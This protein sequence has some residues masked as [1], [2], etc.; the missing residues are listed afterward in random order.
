MCKVNPQYKK[1]VRNER[2]KKVLYL[3]V[4]KALYGCI[5]SAFFVVRDVYNSNLYLVQ[6]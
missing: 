1:Q 4:L 5:E 2:G 3:R 6:E